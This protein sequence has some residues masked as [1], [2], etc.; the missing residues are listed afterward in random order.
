MFRASDQNR[1]DERVGGLPVLDVLAISNAICYVVDYKF[2]G[3]VDHRRKS[4]DYFH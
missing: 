4:V 1:T 2:S 3:K